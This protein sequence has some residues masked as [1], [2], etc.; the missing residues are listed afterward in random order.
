MIDRICWVN[1]EHLID[2]GGLNSWRAKCK[3]EALLLNPTY[4]PVLILRRVRGPR[5]L[6]VIALGKM[7]VGV[8]NHTYTKQQWQIH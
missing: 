5:K 4:A 3:K 6:G 2:L 1:V 8:E 7:W